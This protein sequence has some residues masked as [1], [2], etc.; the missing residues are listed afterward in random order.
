MKKQTLISGLKKI[1]RLFLRVTDL[2]MNTF[3]LTKTRIGFLIGKMSQQKKFSINQSHRDFNDLISTLMEA[4]KPE[5][6]N[7][8]SDKG[9][10]KNSNKK[11]KARKSL[12][13]DKYIPLHNKPSIR[14]FKDGQNLQGTI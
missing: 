14:S 2:F 10:V 4:I 12:D 8:K 1:E 13:K 6:R 3:F 7:Q 9:Q 5:A 11:L